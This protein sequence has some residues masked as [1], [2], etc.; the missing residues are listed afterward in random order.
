MDL[1]RAQPTRNIWTYQVTSIAQS[2]PT[3]GARL[4]SDEIIISC[5]RS[6]CNLTGKATRRYT[7]QLVPLA[8]MALQARHQAR[9][10]RPHL[11]MKGSG[12]GI[13]FHDKSIDVYPWVARSANYNNA[14]GVGAW[15][16]EPV[17]PHDRRT[18]VGR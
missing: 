15:P 14:D 13:A 7:H 5:E 11:P 17:S 8:L 10:H 2:G 4:P 6:D 16:R 9:L 18:G 3:V 1:V 12:G